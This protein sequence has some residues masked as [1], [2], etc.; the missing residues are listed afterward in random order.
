MNAMTYASNAAETATEV[1]EPSVAELLARL[2][3]LGE[4]IRRA[5]QHYGMDGRQPSNSGGEKSP[6][7]AD[8]S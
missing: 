4:D 1:H 8:E 3:A 7:D 5:R 6:G 2:A